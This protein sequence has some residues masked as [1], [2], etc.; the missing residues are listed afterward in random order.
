M[1]NND[2]PADIL[3]ATTDPTGTMVNYTKPTA[4]DNEDPNPVVTCDPASGSK[5]AVGTTTVT[6]TARD[7][8]GNV[9][10]REDLQGRR[11]PRRPGQ[12]HACRAPSRPRCR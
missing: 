2:V 6:C 4:T 8:N 9:S 5:F 11:P 3:V 1:L 7:A 12:R 10:A